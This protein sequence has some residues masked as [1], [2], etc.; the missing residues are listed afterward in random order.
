[1]TIKDIIIYYFVA[2]NLTI[3]I[4]ILT[5]FLLNY[6]QDYHIVIVIKQ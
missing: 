1:M 5:R 2:C 3:I 6:I 4:Y